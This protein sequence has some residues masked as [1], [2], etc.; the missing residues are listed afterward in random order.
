[1][2]TVLGWESGV[3]ELRFWQLRISL[4]ACDPT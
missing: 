2:L 4:S 1:M 3:G